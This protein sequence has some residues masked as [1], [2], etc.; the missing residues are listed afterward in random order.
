M[1]RGKRSSKHAPCA[2]RGCKS[3]VRKTDLCCG[4]CRVERTGGFHPDK[5]D[6]VPLMG[7][8]GY[9]TSWDVA[10]RWPK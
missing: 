9:D 3:I 10:E 4:A 5:D 2:G 7:M 6:G 8:A 1:G